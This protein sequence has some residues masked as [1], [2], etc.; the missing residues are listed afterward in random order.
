MNDYKP[1][2][3]FIA[4]GLL[5]VPASQGGAIETLITNLIDE[6]EEYGLLNL[7]VAT[8]YD[9]HSLFLS[10]KYRRT[11]FITIA[12]NSF[13][14]RFLYRIKHFLVKRINNNYVPMYN[15]YYSS[16]LRALTRKP[17]HYYDAV[18]FE[19]GPNSAPERYFRIF[20]NRLWY[21]LHYVPE[22]DFKSENYSTV[23]SVSDFAGNAWRTH[24]LNN[25]DTQ[26][27][28]VHNGID[29][30]AFDKSICFEEKESLRA[31]LGLSSKDFVTLFCGR[32]IP[33]KGV[34]EL[35]KAIDHIPDKH[36]KLLI[37][38]SP[39]FALNSHTEYM[40]SVE[41]YVNRLSD[42]VIFTGYVPN[43]HLWRYASLADIQVVPSLWEDAAP[44]VCL[45]AM[46]MGL[47]LLVTQ[48]GGI[49]EYVTP[50]CAI[51]IPK[52]DSIVANL[53]SAIEALAHDPERLRSM[54]INAKLRSR[55]FTKQKFYERFVA[56]VNSLI[57]R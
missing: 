20:K 34:L 46:A 53:A 16:C 24:C 14:I 43:D 37:I 1:N 15:Y 55:E 42:R 22:V 23:L 7:T 35:L 18:I 39:N 57:N 36:I 19:G 50:E 5:P 49:Q 25:D 29:S 28:T 27:V 44:T 33:V 56:T 45:E 17:N 30:A 12:K 8:I 21:H 32:I 6:N 13:L 31:S 26:I 51:T 48:S 47:P 40:D 52:D 2:V 41:Q 54:S 11:N 4:P 9:E 38:G 10:K 3:C